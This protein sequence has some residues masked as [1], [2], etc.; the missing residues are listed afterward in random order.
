MNSHQSAIPNFFAEQLLMEGVP[1]LAASGSVLE[2]TSLFSDADSFDV[3]P[4]LNQDGK[5]VGLFS[6]ADLVR[7]R[8]LLDTKEFLELL[9][10]GLEE[11]YPNISHSF[12]LETYQTAYEQL[13][14]GDVMSPLP[15]TLRPKTPLTEILSVFRESQRNVV[16]VT[17]EDGDY[18]GLM[19]GSNLLSKIF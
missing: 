8:Q 19:N 6:N 11:E 9:A 7:S 16:P 10:L 3:L 13:T 2:A 5:L 14:F 15:D 12:H 18:V 4:V 1:T 17:T